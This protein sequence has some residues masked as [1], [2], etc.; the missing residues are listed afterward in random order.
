MIKIDT[1]GEPFATIEAGGTTE[2]ITKELIT[3]ISAIASGIAQQNGTMGAINAIVM[4]KAIG[5]TLNDPDFISDTLFD[6]ERNEWMTSVVQEDDESDEEAR[7]RGFQEAWRKYMRSTKSRPIVVDE[8][9]K[10]VDK[11]DNE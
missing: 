5:E 11:E 1:S 6:E 4:L 10:V 8:N 3:A 2:E 7:Q 9:Y